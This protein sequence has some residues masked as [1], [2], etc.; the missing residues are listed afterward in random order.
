MIDRAA[1][2]YELNDIKR[3]ARLASYVTVNMDYDD[4]AVGRLDA[5]LSMLT[6]EVFAMER[7]LMDLL[8]P[9]KDD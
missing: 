5:M 2:E 1:I 7:R 4:N 8:Y 9:P 6:N 3:F